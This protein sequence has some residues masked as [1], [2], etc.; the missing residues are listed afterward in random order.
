MRRLASKCAAG[1]VVT[2][3]ADHLTPHQLGVG[4]R[5]GAEAI[6]HGVNR[7]IKENA[8]RDDLSLLKIDFSNAFNAISRKAVFEQVRLI[9][10]SISNWVEFC[11]GTKP[12]LFV[13][14]H[15]ITSESG[16]QQGDPLGPLLFSLALQ[17]LVSMTGR[18]LAK[19]KIYEL[20]SK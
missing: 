14:E 4:V 11:Y 2:E 3:C 16:V 18:L 10:P 7:V 9:S 20:S 17:T 15:L 5:G 13:G 1:A 8:H 12:W 6:V 19:S